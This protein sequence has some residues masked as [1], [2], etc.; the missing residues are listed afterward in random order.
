MIKLYNK[1]RCSKR[2]V[3]NKFMVA[4]RTTFRKTITEQLEYNATIIQFVLEIAD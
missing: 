2:Q 1:I 4:M 3:I